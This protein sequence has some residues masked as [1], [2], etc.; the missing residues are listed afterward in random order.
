MRI[1]SKIYVGY[2]DSAEKMQAAISHKLHLIS[3]I[4]WMHWILYF[5]IILL[6]YW[7][8]IQCHPL[9]RPH[10]PGD[11]ERQV[12]DLQTHAVDKVTALV[13]T[14]GGA[15]VAAYLKNI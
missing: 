10:L 13:E 12:S 3:C 1:S 8:I 14:L 2:S 5:L 11:L 15:N 6:I 9:A 7:F 4:Y